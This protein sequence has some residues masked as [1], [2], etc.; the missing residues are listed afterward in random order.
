MAM[1]R[2]EFEMDEEAVQRS[3]SES[4]LLDEELLQDRRQMVRSR[5]SDA[6]ADS[7]GSGAPGRRKR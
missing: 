7:N 5:E 2:A 4:T 3:I 6:S 1:L